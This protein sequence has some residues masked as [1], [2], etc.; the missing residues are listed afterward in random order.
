MRR[1]FVVLAAATALAVGGGAA[2]ADPAD[3]RRN[4]GGNIPAGASCVQPGVVVLGE[5]GLENAPCVCYVT[6]FGRFHALGR[7]DCPSG[8]PEIKI[9]RRNVGG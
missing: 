4:L 1:T 6:E 5:G 8:L 3:A 9:D 7:G 2:T